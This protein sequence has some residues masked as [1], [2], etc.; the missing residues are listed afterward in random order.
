MESFPAKAKITGLLD[1]SKSLEGLGSAC[2]YSNCSIAQLLISL[3]GKLHRHM[4]SPFVNQRNHQGSFKRIVLPVHVLSADLQHSMF[5]NR[6]QRHFRTLCSVGTP[7]TTKISWFRQMSCTLIW[8][9]I[10]SETWTA[11]FLPFSSCSKWT[12][13]HL[14]CRSVLWLGYCCLWDFEL[15]DSLASMSRYTPAA[16]NHEREDVWEL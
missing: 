16:A 6:I 13:H 2:C 8:H 5:G 10:G 9:V 15:M 4:W 7:G 1:V 3:H 11:S 14:P 12:Y